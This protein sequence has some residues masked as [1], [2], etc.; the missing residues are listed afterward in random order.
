LCFYGFLLK[1]HGR[2]R[3]FSLTQIPVHYRT[4]R[5]DAGPGIVNLTRTPVWQIYTCDEN[6]SVSSVSDRN[7]MIS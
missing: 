2:S 5:P 1:F 6:M 7:Q 4:A 3:S